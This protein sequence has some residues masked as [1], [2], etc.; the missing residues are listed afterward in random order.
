MTCAILSLDG[1][2]SFFCI[3]FAIFRMGKVRD[4]KAAFVIFGG[5]ASTP[6]AFLHHVNNLH[7]L[8]RMLTRVKYQKSALSFSIW[9]NC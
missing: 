7:G 1:K 4:G 3:S 9:V 6:V 2:V 8:E 5:R